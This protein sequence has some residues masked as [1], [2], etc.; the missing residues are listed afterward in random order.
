MT[1]WWFPV[2][3]LTALSMLATTG[4][5]QSGKNP[6]AGLSANTTIKRVCADAKDAASAAK[7]IWIE[8]RLSDAIAAQQLEMQRIVRDGGVSAARSVV[9]GLVARLR[10][11]SGANGR[12]DVE[13]LLEEELRAAGLSMTALDALIAAENLK[14][15]ARRIATLNRAI[16][17]SAKCRRA[18]RARLTKA[19]AAKRSAAAALNDWNGFWGSSTGKFYEVKG[20]SFYRHGTDKVSFTLACGGKGRL[21]DRIARIARKSIGKIEGPVCTGRW[22]WSSG[23]VGGDMQMILRSH[24]SSGTPTLTGVYNGVSDPKSWYSIGYR[25][26]TPKEIVYHGLKRFTKP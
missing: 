16:R 22:F 3:A 2:A 18:A 11:Q 17:G 4:A 21:G 8:A 14:A 20:K 12:S 6:Y 19:A 9:S 25:K 15:A 24:K 13:K 26:L 7:I 10:G 23:L 5:A 1:R